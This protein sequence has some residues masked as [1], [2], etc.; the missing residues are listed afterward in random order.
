ML[1]NSSLENVYK[2]VFRTQSSTKYSVI[3]IWC[4]SKYYASILF[5]IHFI[6]IL[7]KSNKTTKLELGLITNVLWKGH[8]KDKKN[9]YLPSWDIFS[10]A[11]NAQKPYDINLISLGLYSRLISRCHALQNLKLVSTIY[12]FLSN[13]YFLPKDSP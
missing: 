5:C 3:D 8:G 4:G 13:S 10:S 7:Q 1:Y 2:N 9:F 6:K 11:T 12:Y